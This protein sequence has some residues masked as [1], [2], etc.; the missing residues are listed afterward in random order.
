MRKLALLATVV[1]FLLITIIASS[2]WQGYARESMPNL[3]KQNLEFCNVI[4]NDFFFFKGMFWMTCNGRPYYAEVYP[5]G[6]SIQNNGWSFISK[7]I[8]NQG[9][10]NE[11]TDDGCSFLSSNNSKMLFFCGTGAIRMY[12]FDS[13]S[14][15]MTKV[16]E[17]NF[18]KHYSNCFY[19]DSSLVNRTVVSNMR[20]GN[21]NYETLVRFNPDY[22]SYQLP[23]VTDQRLSDVNKIFKSFDI[24]FGNSC[25]IESME[26]RSSVY[27]LN[28]TCQES[29][30]TVSYDMKNKVSGI[31]FQSSDFDGAFSLL[32][33]RIFPIMFPGKPEFLESRQALSGRTDLYI[34][35]GRLLAAEITSNDL[36]RLMHIISEGPA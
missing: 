14:F 20:C 3:M 28:L 13:R 29:N 4:R 8:P 5:I 15:E 16:G 24:S 25:N 12:N 30:L 6:L 21:E 26:N 18:T 7:D 36:V 32:N 19:Y 31:Y 33:S 1:A 10:L 9:I 35:N 11:L 2:W 22:G 23:I 27:F 34:W 17:V